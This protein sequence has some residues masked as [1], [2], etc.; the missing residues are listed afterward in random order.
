[1]VAVFYC[2][3]GAEFNVSPEETIV[4]VDGKELGKADDWDG[5]G[6]GQ[7]YFFSRPGKHYVKL[8]LAGYR[9]TWIEII[10]APTAGD[11]IA[12]VDTRLPEL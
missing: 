5:K 9:T 8:A 6:G 10:V 7:T 3:S 2:Q 1:M 12:D 11:E 4:T